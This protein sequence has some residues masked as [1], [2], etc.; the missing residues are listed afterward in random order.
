MCPWSLG[1]TCLLCMNTEPWC[2]VNSRSLYLF[3]QLVPTKQF[4]VI[5]CPLLNFRTNL[6]NRKEIRIVSFLT[7]RLRCAPVKWFAWVYTARGQPR[8]F[9]QF[10]STDLCC[11]AIRMGAEAWYFPCLPLCLFYSA[12]SHNSVLAN[13]WFNTHWPHSVIRSYQGRMV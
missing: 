2:L 1:W 6:R 8:A 12:S 10:T 5:S 13:P 11:Q 9:S 4:H 3:V 7:N